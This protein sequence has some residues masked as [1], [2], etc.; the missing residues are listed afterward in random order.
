MCQCG[1]G[2]IPIEDA[3]V[4]PGGVVIGIRVYDGCEDCDT[5]PGIDISVFPSRNSE[6]LECAKFHAL[7]PDQFGGV[8]DDWKLPGLPIGL[9]TP[10][11]L[12]S[13]ARELEE[14]CGSVGQGRDDYPTVRDWIAD[15][16]I[17]LVQ[18][19]MRNFSKRAK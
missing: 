5:G 15:H 8:V 17:R 3:Y 2:E 1:C 4:L 19:A 10:M 13:A 12:C 6:W 16:G 11:D 18:I 7:N 9:F 14:E